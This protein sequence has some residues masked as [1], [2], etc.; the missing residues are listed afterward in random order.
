MP[1]RPTP[2]FSIDV[3]P[4]LS[5]SIRHTI[6]ELRDSFQ[7]LHFLVSRHFERES[8]NFCFT[9]ASTDILYNAICQRSFGR[10]NN[11]AFVITVRW[12]SLHIFSISLKN[13]LSTIIWPILKSQF[14]VRRYESSRVFVSFFPPKKAH[15]RDTST[16][17]TPA[18]QLNWSGSDTHTPP[19]T[20]APQSALSPAVPLSPLWDRLHKPMAPPIGLTWPALVTQTPGMTLSLG[21]ARSQRREGVTTRH[22]NECG[23][24]L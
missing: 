9:V 12:I 23:C 1:R 10:A 16:G 13:S 7:Y 5:G 22:L 15:N 24:N 18:V 17:S 8:L 6:T 4:K 19:S 11:R 14:T 3:S 20:T 21:C 2:A